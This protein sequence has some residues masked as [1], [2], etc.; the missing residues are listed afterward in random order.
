[1]HA[2]YNVSIAAFTA[3]IS[4]QPTLGFVDNTTV[5]QYLALNGAPTNFTLGQSEAKTQGNWR[6]KYILQSLALM[7]NP[8]VSNMTATGGAANADPTNFSF[9][10]YFERDSAVTTYDNN[11]N[12]LIGAPAVAFVVASALAVTQSPVL[13]YYDPTL[14]TTVQDDLTTGPWDYDDQRVGTLVI[15]ALA[16]DAPTALA[17]ITVTV[18][19]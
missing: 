13:E 3:G 7:A 6:W 5:Q 16:V 17:N 14:S 4:A 12:V 1:M 10:V 11:G 9:D 8:Y 15:G 2:L 19:A 18:I